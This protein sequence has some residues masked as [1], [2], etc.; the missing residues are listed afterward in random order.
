VPQ[1]PGQLPCAK[2][3]GIQQHGRVAMREQPA[4]AGRCDP[5]RR[6]EGERIMEQSRD[7]AAAHAAAGSD[8]LGPRTGT[9]TWE[10]GS[11]CFTTPAIH[12]AAAI[13]A[14]PTMHE[15]HTYLL[16]DGEGSVGRTPSTH[17]AAGA[18]LVRAVHGVGAGHGRGHEKGCS[19]Q[20]GSDAHV[21][22]LGEAEAKSA[23]KDRGNAACGSASAVPSS[24]PGAEGGPRFRQGCFICLAEALASRSTVHEAQ[25]GKRTAATRTAPRAR[26]SRIRC[27]GSMGGRR[28]HTQSP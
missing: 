22:F 17:A 19:D 1:P 5:A 10:A 14:G 23:W 21:D 28:H 25:A 12:E 18:E 26:V 9:A 2:Y 8:G 7:C 11:P 15:W 6:R 27:P 3:P 24:S 16:P 4:I 20:D 13:A